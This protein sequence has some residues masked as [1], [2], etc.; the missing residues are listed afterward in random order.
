MILVDMIQWISLSD[1]TEPDEKHPAGCPF[2]VRPPAEPEPEL[3][4][5]EKKQILLRI[6]Y[7]N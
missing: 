7:D 4:V 6:F 1:T 5:T 3:G 2:L